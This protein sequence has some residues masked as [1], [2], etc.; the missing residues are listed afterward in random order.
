MCVALI[1]IY[2]IFSVF[3]CF[4]RTDLLNLTLALLCLCIVLLNYLEDWYF[5][6]LAFLLL[7]SSVCDVVWLAANH[8]SLS[9]LI[10]DPSS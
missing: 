5:S 2:V 6:T 7:A 3:E 10:H 8:S 9:A 4:G 1:A